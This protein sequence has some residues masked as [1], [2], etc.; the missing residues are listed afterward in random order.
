MKSAMKVLFYSTSEVTWHKLV[1]GKGSI[2]KFAFILWL[3]IKRKL[4]T[5][6]RLSKWGIQNVSP[7]CVL[8]GTEPEFVDHLFF[9]CG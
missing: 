4:M 7:M 3:A 5:S 6:D 9:R 8:R 2:P 1:W